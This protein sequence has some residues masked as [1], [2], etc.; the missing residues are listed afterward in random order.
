MV[1][2]PVCRISY[3]A[4]TI[5]CPECGLYLLESKEIGT[6]PLETETQGEVSGVAHNEG[7]HGI[8]LLTVRL[9]ICAS[10]PLEV[11]STSRSP[12]RHSRSRIAKR[13]GVGQGN[14]NRK[15]GTATRELEVPLTKPVRLGRLDPREG[16]YPDVDLTVDLAMENGVSREHACIFRRGNAVEIE[17]LA[18]TNGTMLNGTRLSPYLPIPI[19]EGDQIQLGKLLIEVSFR[20]SCNRHATTETRIAPAAAH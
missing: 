7:L 11:S 8:G 17:D 12:L 9:R 2:C 19:K 15:N 5:F 3:V 10:N 6:D 13:S 4:N 18:S 16:V 14:R 20:P 1:Q